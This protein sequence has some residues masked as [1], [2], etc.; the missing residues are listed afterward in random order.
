V[1]SHLHYDY[2]TV[3]HITVDVLEDQSSQAGGAA[4][5]S[6]LQ[7]ARLGQRTLIV[8]RGVPRQIEALI[9]PYRAELDVRI[10]PA[11]HTT[12]LQ[13]SGSGAA[14]RQRLL[15]WAGPIQQDLALSS[16]ILHLAP[17]VR[18]SPTRWRGT[19][20]F[21]GLTP[22]G[23]ARQWNGPR[24]HVVD[25]L[26]TR[27]AMR[28]APHCSALVLSQ[29]EHS[30]CAR[31]IDRA[32]AAGAV[33]AIT[34]GHRPTTIIEPRH[35][36]HLKLAAPV[37]HAPRDDLGAGDVFA[38]AFFIALAQHQQPLD[39]ARFA[40]AAA[41]VRMSGLGADAIGGLAEVEAQLARG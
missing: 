13:T 11:S 25:A 8:T 21:V 20:E 5:Y 31:L 3:G 33:T 16:S 35:A 40:G 24:K 2:T 23:L 10:L 34:D 27:A 22:Q 30:S 39:A 17:V 36:A 15:A 12:T 29:H 14:R 41:A 19:A 37:I 28:V 6:A 32:S 9:E 38:A 18:E 7:A 26:P 4:F 1:N